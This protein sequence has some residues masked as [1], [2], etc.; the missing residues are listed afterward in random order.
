[1][2]VGFFVWV[3]VVIVLVCS[4]AALA[5]T[6][7]APLDEYFGRMKLSPLGIENIIHDTNLRVRYDPVHAA[8]Y[9]ATLAS[10]EDAL[11]DWARKYPAD[12]WLPGRAYYMSHVFWAMHT[13]EADVA[14][15][16]CR[17]MLFSQFGRSHWARL[18]E[19][20]TEATVA[21][22]PVAQAAQIKS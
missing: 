5:T 14:A 7:V 6:R 19:H 20:E 13:K 1:M 2:R 21:P 18:A 17:H 10:A 12:P 16:H 4:S 15:E 9:Y 22:L 3:F 8:R 11:D